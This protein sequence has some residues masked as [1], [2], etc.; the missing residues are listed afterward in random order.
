MLT[1]FSIVSNCF[2]Q[3]KTLK[4]I[5]LL[6]DKGKPKQALILLSK[7]NTIGFSNEDL[8][9]YYYLNA[10]SFN[11]ESNHEKAIQHYLLAKKQYLKARVLDKAMDI[12]L[13]IAFII[14]F[15]HNDNSKH[16]FYLKEYMNYALAKRD[17]Y[18]ILKG[19]VQIAS[20]KINEKEANESLF[21][22]RKALHGL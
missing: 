8:G 1:L 13:D 14:Y 21:Y 2:G 18:K 17:N 12:N 16:L 11:K 6:I 15:F 22:F 19:Y 4:T 10:K 3:N 5:D 20:L 7:I 9:Y